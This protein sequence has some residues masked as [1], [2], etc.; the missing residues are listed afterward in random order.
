MLEKLK[1][2][3]I[4][5]RA[6]QYQHII[7]FGLIPLFLIGADLN[8]FIWYYLL[9]FLLTAF[10]FMINDY[11]DEKMDKEAG[12]NTGLTKG[13]V[14][15]STLRALMVIF[16][17]GSVV[18]AYYLNPSTILLYLIIVFFVWSYSAPPFRFKTRNWLE[19]PVVILGFGPLNYLYTAASLGYSNTIV[20]LLYFLFAVSLIG[21]SQLNNCLKDFKS[22][23]FSGSKNL[24]QTT[25]F[26]KALWIRR[27]FRISL[28]L[29]LAG[30]YLYLPVHNLF[31]VL[32]F[33]I[34]AADTFYDASKKFENQR[35]S[36]FT[37]TATAA[38]LLFT[39]F[40][41]F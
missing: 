23:K 27:M 32:V 19:M 16:L 6:H 10:G 15:K 12:K 38:I 21:Q 39:I 34:F 18:L 20:N 22:D 33:W 29:L 35:D 40:Q 9:F 37:L 41:Y 14:S 25:G 5:T 7:F 31:M 3:V 4:L 8:Y 36:S 1:L 24:A 17:F 2:F 11:F 30:L 26:E 13:F 28:P